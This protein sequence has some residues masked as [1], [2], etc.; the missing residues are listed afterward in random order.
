MI[1]SQLYDLAHTGDI[2]GVNKW[3]ERNPDDLNNYITD[4]FTPLHVACIFGHEALVRSL[5][6]RGALVNLNARNKSEATAL[7]LATAF[8][9]E[10][11]AQRLVLLLLDNG[12]ELN[13]PQAG[14]QTALHHAVARG[15]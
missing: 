11:I 7:H 15:S 10:K 3:L 12:A 2:E 13:S 5:L 6:S 1:T 9:D 8:R 14:G 4:G